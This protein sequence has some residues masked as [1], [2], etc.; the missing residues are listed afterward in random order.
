MA[1]AAELVKMGYDYLALGGMVPLKA[2]QIMG[3]LKAVSA[4]PDDVQ[5]HILTAKADEV[6][7]LHWQRIG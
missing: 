5:V 4:I 1:G 2:E 7:E 3:A 6:Q